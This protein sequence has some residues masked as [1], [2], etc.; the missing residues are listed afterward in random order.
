MTVAVCCFEA[1]MTSAGGLAMVEKQETLGQDMREG[2][3]WR[4]IRGKGQDIQI[5]RSGAVSLHVG[6]CVG[7]GRISAGLG[8]SP[9][10]DISTSS[11]S[12]PEHLAF[13]DRGGLLLFITL[14]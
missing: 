4:T 14:I 3:D 2:F 13:L 1:G 8:M 5:Y 11:R 7:A 12:A 6:G 9:C 10:Q